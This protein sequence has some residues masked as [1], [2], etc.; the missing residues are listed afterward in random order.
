[1]DDADGSIGEFAY[2][3]IKKQLQYL[4][5]P[6]VHT[7]KILEL[8][9]NID[10]MQPFR[11]SKKSAWPIL[12]HI[13]HEDEIYEPF[14]IAFYFGASKPKNLVHFLRKFVIEINGLLQN[15]IEIDSIHFSVKIKF[16]T[17]DIP[18]R[19]YLKCC[20]PHIA[21]KAC[22]RCKIRGKKIDGT[23]CFIIDSEYKKKT[24][25]SFRSFSDPSYH[26]NVSPL[27]KITPPINLINDFIIE[28]LHNFYLGCMNRLL[29]FWL[30]RPTD[31]KLRPVLR[32]ELERRTKL[33]YND[34]CSEFKRKMR[35]TKDFGQYKAVELAFF[36]RICG[37][38]VL[39]KF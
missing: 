19:T 1:M 22:E 8:R 37:P 11:S 29:E 5:N 10:G 26:Y 27:I 21:S 36:L 24:N 18:S 6:N 25:E 9:F 23:M 33:I 12:C 2:L 32:K 7:I 3:G 16:F 4:V 30:V 39:K 38:I 17:C 14:T 13:F 15:G 31:I 34:I 28:P 35:S 20:A